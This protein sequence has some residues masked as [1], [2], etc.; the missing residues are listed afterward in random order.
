MRWAFHTL[1]RKSTRRYVL[2]YLSMCGLCFCGGARAADLAW[3]Q[4]NTPQQQIPGQTAQRKGAIQGILRDASNNPVIG[5]T[6][7]LR[8]Q[9]NGFELK[10][11]SDAQGVFRFID[12]VPG[13][14]ELEI[15]GE[16]YEKFVERDIHVNAGDGL[17]REIT[18]TAAPTATA[19][20]PSN[21]PLLPQRVAPNNPATLEAP[22]SISYPEARQNLELTTGSEMT[23]PA[24]PPQ[25][26]PVFSAEPDRW[27]LTMPEWNRYGKGGEHP[28]VKG[29]LWDP[30][31]TN[32][33]KGDVPI[34]GQQTF[35]DFTAITDTFVDGRRL[36]TPTGV[37]T[38]QPGTTGFFGKGNQAFVDQVFL[39][40]FELFHGDTSFR[41][42]DWRIRITPAISLNYLDVQEL[43]IVNVDVRKGT[44]RLDSH[45]GLQE[46]FAEVKLRD[47][48]PN[49]DFISVRAG[50]QGFNSDFR[51]FLFVEEQPGIRIFGNLESNRW[52]YNLAYFN[53]LEKN[54]NSGLNS[55]ALRNQQVII[56]NV[57]RQ[58]FLFQGYTAQFSVHYNKDDATIHYDDNGFLVR[59]APIGAVFSQGILHPH[60]I[61]A[62]YLGWTG[63][64]HIGPINLTHAFY[65]ALGNDSFNGIAGRPVT[66][67]AQ[68]A[69]LELSVD[70]DWIRFKGSAFYSS[71]AAHPESGHARGFDS[72][73]DFPEFAG[74][75]FSLWN[76]ESIRLTGT[77][78][79]LNSGN[80][81]IPDL[82]SNKDEGQSN[83]VNPGIFLVN[84]GAD[85]DVTPKLRGFVNVNYLRF[86][87]TEPLEL[88]LFDSPIHHAIG[89][90]SSVGVRYR[91]P[92]TENISITAGAA[93]LIPGQ[94]LRD[95]YTG[96]TLFSF[97]T[98]I[99]FQF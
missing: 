32:K 83:F 38:A 5:A 77:G 30:F 60:S 94:G 56:G 23:A 34:F 78:V 67:N 55:M 15:E 21:L 19:N 17:I 11:N 29:K 51:G 44:T 35:F 88:V 27:L 10:K 79:A 82:R 92:L 66:I 13:S 73:D 14:Y 42:V 25:A 46:A 24:A 54:T 87:D 89:T 40:S 81:L 36:P 58:D 72:I 39:F 68:M 22:P 4:Q 62:A 2:M 28:Y 86:M 43:G 85:F 65:Q 49:F 9:A 95:I 33:L 61:H 96:K 70:K 76:R 3:F 50:I 48:S 69:A 7:L 84:A 16:G 74:G 26:E 45:I 97:F 90:D 1:W 59:P 47:L 98:D 80:S 18:I 6:V 53:F 91:P 37:S 93:T 71:G 75:I 99:R 64:G 31:D 20:A 12:I 8:N 52:Q 63:D 57:Y 41:P